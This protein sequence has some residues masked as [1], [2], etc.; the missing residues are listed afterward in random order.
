MGAALLRTFFASV[1][2]PTL[3]YSHK[4]RQLTPTVGLMRAS[5][6]RSMTFQSTTMFIPG[7]RGVLDSLLFIIGKFGYLS[8]QELELPKVTG[9]GT[10][11]LPPASVRVGLIS[12]AQLGHRSIKLGEVDSDPSGD[13][14]DH[15]QAG[16]PATKDLIY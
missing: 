14:A 3:K 9:S 2:T 5:Y 16:S 11:H 13:K 1:S 8:L 4:R 6:V 12:E 15:N 10:I 7:L